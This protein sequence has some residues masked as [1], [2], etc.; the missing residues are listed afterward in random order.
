M[1]IISADAERGKEYIN[2]TKPISCK[3][4]LCKAWERLQQG[5]N[6]L[7]LHRNITC[8]SVETAAS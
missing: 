8:L 4:A 6:D 2:I 1:H 3:A 5:D 7:L